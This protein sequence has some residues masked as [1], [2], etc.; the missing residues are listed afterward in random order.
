MKAS[1]LAPI[2]VLDHNIQTLCVRINAATYEL[3]VMIREFDERAGWL[4]W[5]LNSCAEWLAWRCD[6]ALTTA[7][8]KVRVAHAIKLLPAI[9]DRYAI[10]RTMIAVTSA[11]SAVVLLAHLL[12]ESQI[13]LFAAILLLALLNAP[14]VPIGEALGLR[15]A[16]RY[17]FAYAR[18]RAAGSV[19]FLIANIA[20]GSWVGSI[21]PDTV[22]WAGAAGLLVTA[23]VG[24][25]HPGGGAAAGSGADRASVSEI[26][27]LARVQVFVLFAAT[28]AIG[29][30]GHAVYYIYSVLD[31]TAQGIGTNVIGWL[32]ATGVLAETA[33][34]L[35]PGRRWVTRIG[36]GGALAMAALAGVLR[37]A[38]MALEPSAAMLWP[39]QAL[40]ALTFGLG[41][42][43]RWRLSLR[44]FPRA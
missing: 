20:V 28:A 4:Q 10:R 33:L 1:D 26:L 21:G 44:R 18:V 22:I 9:A 29:Q 17:H 13:L 24:A 8:E 36:P 19:A 7:R 40:H 11:L 23:M 43:A 32:W 14:A 37:W 6:L 31:W 2:D 12:I 3:L 16:R 27:R 42:L 25:I 34:M 5:G 15:A 35:G 38:A 39:V 41:H 30:A